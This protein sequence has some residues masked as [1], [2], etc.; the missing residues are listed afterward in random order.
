[1][2]RKDNNIISAWNVAF[3]KLKQGSGFEDYCA[4]ANKKHGEVYMTVDFPHCRPEK[5]LF[6]HVFPYFPIENPPKSINRI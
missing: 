1:M 6:S 4:A 2:A 3:T 5:R